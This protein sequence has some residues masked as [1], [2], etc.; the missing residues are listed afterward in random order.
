MREHPTP[1][2]R[3]N[4][5]LVVQ[6]GRLFQ[7]AH[8]DVPVIADHGRYLLVE[9]DP[10]RAGSIGAGD[11]TCYAVRTLDDGLVAF[12]TREAVA[13]RQPEPWIQ[14]LVDRVSLA[15][16]Q[17]DLTH[18]AQLPTRH[19]TSTHYAQGSAWARQQLLNM[20]YTAR[21]RTIAV[22]TRSSQNVIADKSG[23]GTGP[24][25]LILVTAHLDSINT[26]G[27][28]A[29]S[30]P[31]AD[32][33]GSG[34][35]GLL[36]IARALK[37][38]PG[39]HDLRFVLFG[40]EEQGLFGSK[41]YVGG[42]T[43]AERAR[44]RAVVNM[45][46]IG[47]LNTPPP[48]T[49]IEGDP[50]SQQVIDS[51]ADAAATYTGLAVQTSLHAANSDHVPFIRAGIPAV[52]TIEGADN[53]NRNIHSADDT[54]DHINFDLALEILRMNVAFVAQALGRT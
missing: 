34:S 41:A 2:E 1:V 26:R 5:Y 7:D 17:A 46:M 24:R 47:T 22:G 3:D 49:L 37:D 21:R 14:S 54:L 9:L 25:D 33:N 4:L 43:A 19:S 51:L 31:G 16:F 53:T 23:G 42:L 28:A 18:L 27:G 30:A 11:E 50:V 36:E 6:N 13:P 12:E 35:A 10:V 15:T 45:D 20:D 32:D 40:G 39:V 44:I 52:L 38:H 48:A 8:P 29:A